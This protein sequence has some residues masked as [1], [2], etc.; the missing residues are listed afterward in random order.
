MRAIPIVRAILLAIG[1][2]GLTA[3]ASATSYTIT[4][5]NVP[6]PYGDGIAQ[7]LDDTGQVVGNFSAPPPQDPTIRTFLYQNGSYSAIDVVPYRGTPGPSTQATAINNVG[8]IVGT[9]YS[10]SST[11]AF[12]YRN[13]VF[14]DLGF[15]GTSLYSGQENGP[16][17]IN[18]S[19]VIVGT[20]SGAGFTHGFQYA[21]G[22]LTPI[23]PPGAVQTSIS[24][25]S[26]SGTIA[27]SYA[28]SAGQE[29]G[30]LYKDGNFTT[31]DF[32]DGPYDTYL[33]AINAD[34]IAVGV[35]GAPHGAGKGAGFFSYNDGVFSSLDLPLDLGGITG[36]NDAGQFLLGS[37]SFGSVSSLLTPTPE[38]GSMF[39]LLA[40]LVGIGW[41]QYRKCNRK[42]FRFEEDPYKHG[43]RRS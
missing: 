27:G 5:L 20:S 34:G 33:E 1:T 18:D 4:T 43:T 31:V 13:G 32:P 11:Y 12:L 29:H 22:I 19:S 14:T 42:S 24:G 23:N 2:L 6:F 9:V 8:D 30:F 21:N 26:N 37:R 16:T 36:F 28:D 38:P 40:G 17:G 41:V 3:S 25:I 10:T 15:Y 35:A 39:L 7:G